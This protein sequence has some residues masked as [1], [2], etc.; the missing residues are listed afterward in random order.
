MSNKQ[1]QE[2]RLIEVFR[3][4]FDKGNRSIFRPDLFPEPVRHH[5][6]RRAPTDNHYLLLLIS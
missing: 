2:T 5:Y 6:A 1:G 3:I 4:L